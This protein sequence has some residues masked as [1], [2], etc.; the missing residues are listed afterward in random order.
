MYH[1]PLSYEEGLRR[2]AFHGS[3]LFRDY[4]PE[5]AAGIYVPEDE[6]DLYQGRNVL[7][8]GIEGRMLRLDLEQVIW[9][10]QN[11]LDSNKLAAVV[12][13]IKNADDKIILKAACGNMHKVDLTTVKESIEYQRDT[14]N[15]VLTTGDDELDTF[16]V[17]PEE[18]LSYY[19]DPDEPLYQEKMQEFRNELLEAQARGDGDLGDWHFTPLDGHHRL[20]G[21]LI[22]GEPYVWAILLDGQYQ[23]IHHRKSPEDLELLE[24]LE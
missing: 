13:G 4:Y 5:S 10:P 9:N 3:G 1:N 15:E 7:W 18:V 19:A 22:A 24:M 23:R 17:D 2:A 12:E 14:P 16:L 21:A 8:D 20:W 6:E 11:I